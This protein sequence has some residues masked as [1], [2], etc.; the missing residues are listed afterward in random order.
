[1]RTNSSQFLHSLLASGLVAI[2]LA[3]C[4]T[5]NPSAN[6]SGGTD[7][8]SG[9]ATTSTDELPAELKDAQKFDPAAT[10]DPKVVQES[11]FYQI[12]QSI[13][14]NKAA[15]DAGWKEQER[16]EASV[17]STAA[18]EEARKAALAKAEEEER[19]RQRQKQI[20]AYES[21]KDQRAKD[22]IKAQEA[23][24]KLPG[25]SNEEVNWKGLED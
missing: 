14:Q 1:M 13:E 12:R 11:D 4:T 2:T 3:A 15:L 16:I 8:V 5:T 23:A 7:P 18:Q 24:K 9:D 17:K 22:E 10:L 19:E 25:I 21:T 6:P 20:E